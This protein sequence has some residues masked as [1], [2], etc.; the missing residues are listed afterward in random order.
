RIATFGPEVAAKVRAQA[1]ALAKTG[2]RQLIID[3]RHTAEGSFETGL[4]AARLF[5]K[6]GTLAKIAGRDPE[7]KVAEQAAPPKPGDKPVKPSAASITQT[8]TATAGDGAI[9]L[10][11]TLL[12]TTGTSG[13][14]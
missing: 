3:I 5:V 4:D 8:I 2:A 7:Q 13:A 11:V 9:A 14:A 6:S 12:V 10:P 1:D